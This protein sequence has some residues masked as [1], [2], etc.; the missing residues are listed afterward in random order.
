MW[1]KLLF[2]MNNILRYGLLGVATAFTLGTSYHLNSQPI[3]EENPDPV[4]TNL[5][6]PL[7]FIES[8]VPQEFNTQWETIGE[9]ETLRDAP[10]VIQHQKAELMGGGSSPSGFKP[11]GKIAGFPAEVSDSGSIY[12]ADYLRVDGPK[13]YE[14]ISVTCKPY[15]WNSYG[16]NDAG[17][18]EIITSTW[19]ADV[20]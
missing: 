19:C 10:A 3:I 18:V 4:P 14:N 11:D 7:D 1:C 16:A 5:V 8:H 13:G 6:Q 20:N 17:W 9:Y 12:R 15:D 2:I